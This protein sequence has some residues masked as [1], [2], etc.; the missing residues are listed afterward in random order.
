[1]SA[2]AGIES[3]CNGDWVRSM[4]PQGASG[5]TA[6]LHKAEMSFNRRSPVGILTRSKNWLAGVACSFPAIGSVQNG[7]GQVKDP[8]GASR[9][10]ALLHEA[11]IRCN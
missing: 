10:T 6:L 9:Q 8:G 1:M 11:E 5:Q 7:Q 4:D 3:A 2:R